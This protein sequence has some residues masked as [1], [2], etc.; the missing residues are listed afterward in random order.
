MMMNGVWKLLT[1]GLFEVRSFYCVPE[2]D[3]PARSLPRR[4]SKGNTYLM[5]F[6][7]QTN[8]TQKLY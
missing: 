7:A 8:K 1:D 3:I 6:Q 2:Q 5:I 4:T